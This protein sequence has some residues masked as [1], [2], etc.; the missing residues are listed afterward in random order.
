M[1]KPDDYIEIYLDARFPLQD[2]EAI[3]CRIIMSKAIVAG[4]LPPAAGILNIA[5]ME[6]EKI[7][8]C[9][10]LLLPDRNLV[11][12]MARIARGAERQPFDKTAQLAVDTMAFAQAMDINIEPSV[13]F[14]E[15]AHLSGNEAA[16]HELAHFRGADQGQA[17]AWIDLAMGRTTSLPSFAPAPLSD[18]DLAAPL[19]RW[20]RNY[21]VSLRIAELELTDATPKHRAISL[22]EW[23]E[24]DFFVAGPGMMYGLMY[25]GPK[26]RKADLFKQLRSPTRDRA[27]AGIKNAA[28]DMTHLSDFSKKVQYAIGENSSVR[29]LFATGDHRLASIARVLF[30]L[31]GEQTS[32]RTDIE[33][34]LQEWW[35]ERE[36]RALAELTSERLI[37]AGTRPPPS[38][39]GESTDP[40][41][42]WTVEAEAR[43]FG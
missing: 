41:H 26:S 20:R 9:T 24:N 12:R 35:P 23:M 21:L 36:A 43:I 34:T 10:F 18:L 27:I 40:I 39:K 29:Y 42:D 1:K 38:F 19:N 3:G 33:A 16:H 31:V 7:S 14:H 15:L 13:A 5:A 22:L 28:W 17:D 2:V 6:Y 8:G 32:L 37:L 11:S 25:F 4:Y 30:S